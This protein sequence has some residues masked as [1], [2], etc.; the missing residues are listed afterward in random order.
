MDQPIDIWVDFASQDDT[1]LPWTFLSESDDPARV[2]PGT[3]IVAGND[4]SA[5]VVEVVDVRRDGVVHLRP[6]PGSVAANAHLLRT[7]VT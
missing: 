1:G 5:A 3:F 2:V 4:Q 6:Q 7:R